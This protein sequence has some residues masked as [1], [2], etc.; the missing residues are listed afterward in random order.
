MVGRR[1]VSPFIDRGTDGIIRSI[2]RHRILVE[3]IAV[4]NAV[5][6]FI[7]KH[8]YFRRMGGFVWCLRIAYSR[9]Y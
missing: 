9:G 4:V 6:V 2:D 5:R 7:Q 1:Q 3:K 8:K